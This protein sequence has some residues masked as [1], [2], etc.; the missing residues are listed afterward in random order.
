MRNRHPGVAA[1]VGTTLAMIATACVGVVTATATPAAAATYTF[2]PVAD[3]YV[4]SGSPSTNYGTSGTLS[5]DDSPAKLMYLK[6]NVS[7]VTGAIT[8]VKLRM[9][10]KNVSGAGSNY[11]GAFRAM[12][13][14]TW[15]ETGVTWN[16]Q[17]A[18]TGEFIGGLG[19][20]SQNLWYELDITSYIRANGTYSI[21][22]ESSSSDGADYDSRETGANAPRLVVTDTAPSTGDP[23]L[24]GAGDIAAEG[25][26]GAEATAK[27]LDA[28][29]GTV[30]TA[31]DNA[32]ED[33]SA[34]NFQDYYHP[35]WGRHK[36]RT[37]PSVGNHEYHTPG[38]SG[39]YNY[40]GA[41]AGDPTKGYYSYDIGNWHVVAINSN[42]GQIG[43]CG[44][45]SA[46]E[47]W[48][49]AD[50]AASSKP[51]T[52]A[53][54][55][56][57][58]F[59]SDFFYNGASEMRPITQALYDYNAEV[60]VAGHAHNYERFAPQDPQGN[61]NNTRGVRHFVAGMG[62]KNH[63]GFGFTEPNSQARNSDTFGVLKFTLH[64]N[65][66]DWEFVPEAGATFSDSGRTACH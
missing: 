44:V 47:R 60:V 39:Y 22:V 51:C 24:V 45:G 5:V 26:Y 38:A 8:S 23:V 33:G 34:Q 27:L 54:W 66:Y 14:T 59:T 57:P 55:H 49:R 62:G 52:I 64:A 1:R 43:G 48:L 13:N 11:G 6:F 46:Q 36:A 19:S 17:P 3:T 53:Y 42:C 50:L 29:P 16:N 41:N 25:S 65:S 20:V 37:R 28:I 31:G 30:F 10:V 18:I 4:N 56:H 12:S 7:G 61:L 15:S 2:T 58:L 40:F 63:Y 21:G 32:Y 35:T 9:H